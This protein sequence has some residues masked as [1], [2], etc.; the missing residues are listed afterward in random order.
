MK[1]IERKPWVR[2]LYL[3][4]AMLALVNLALQ[5]SYYFQRLGRGAPWN[6]WRM[7]GSAVWCPDLPQ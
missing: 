1:E 7:C 6:S 5:M 2:W 3:A 4:W